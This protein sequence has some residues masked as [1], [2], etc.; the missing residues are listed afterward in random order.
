MSR[1]R[2]E[3]RQVS[4]LSLLG[5]ALGIAGLAF[6]GFLTAACFLALAERYGAP[7]ACLYMAGLFLVAALVVGCV[8]YAAMRRAQRRR[9]LRAAAAAR[10]QARLQFLSDPVLLAA[11]LR[12]L[13]SPAARRLAPLAAIAAGL[14]LL[15]KGQRRQPPS[16][17]PPEDKGGQCPS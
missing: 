4:L 5:V 2:D 1:L 11:A 15:V 12:A 17:E 9:R 3:A 16:N 10:S 6:V 13:Q 14:F 8:L 7:V